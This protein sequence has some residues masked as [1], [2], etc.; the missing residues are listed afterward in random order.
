MTQMTLCPLYNSPYYTYSIDLDRV[1][2]GL[3][4]RY[5]SRSKGYMMDVFDAEENPV[6]RNIKIV[7]NYP[8]LEQYS[9]SEVSGE[10]YLFPIEE[11]TI[12]ESGVPDPR[13]VDR[14][15]YL[16]YISPE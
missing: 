4:F 8:L 5:S 10:F 2:Y 1:S 11:T 16:V 14:T 7:P 3:T 12:A 13:R 6:I 9:L 15:H